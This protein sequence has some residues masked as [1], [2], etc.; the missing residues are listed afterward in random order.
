MTSTTKSV[1]L[2]MFWFKV[3]RKYEGSENLSMQVNGLGGV[4]IKAKDPQKLYT[5]YEDKLGFKRDDEGK[6]VLPVE[7]FLHDS[8]IL[9]FLPTDTRYFSP[10]DSPCMLNFQV[11]DL[12]VTL[13]ALADNGVYIEDHLEE[14]EFGRFAWVYDPEGNKIE[15]WEPWAQNLSLID[16]PEAE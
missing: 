6:F 5:W 15:L 9:R 11:Q 3:A 13:S 10:S 16:L 8:T 14:N 7:K 2:Q 12:P 1:L 4:F